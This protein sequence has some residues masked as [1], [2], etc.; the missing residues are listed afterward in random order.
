M[1]TIIMSTMFMLSVCALRKLELLPFTTESNNYTSTQV[2]DLKGQYTD[3]IK[4][5][6][7]E[8]SWCITG[9]DHKIQIVLYEYINLKN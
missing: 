2:L 1:L 9:R 3:L 7:S 5:L 8:K 6:G 4:A